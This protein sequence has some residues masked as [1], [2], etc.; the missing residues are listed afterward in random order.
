MNKKK[1]IYY[2]SIIYLIIKKPS[3][4]QKYAILQNV[5]D[6]KIKKIFTNII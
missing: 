2:L 4:I 3:Y 5:L 6:S 1:N